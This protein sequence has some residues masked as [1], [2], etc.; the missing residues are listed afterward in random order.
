MNGIDI[1]FAIIF[2]YALYKGFRNGLIVELCGIISI[3]AGVFIAY[4]FSDMVAGWLSISGETGYVIAFIIIMIATLLLLG[5]LARIISKIIDFTGFG[6]LNKLMGAIAS[7][8]KIALLAG[9]LTC[10]F[11]VLN[12]QAHWIEQKTLDES[13]LYAPM[14]Q[15]AELVFPYLHLVNP[16][17]EQNIKE[18]LPFISPSQE[19]EGNRQQ[20]ETGLPEKD[21]GDNDTGNKTNGDNSIIEI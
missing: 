5:I 4:H 15:I 11:D 10:A 14:E 2:L 18:I 1:F 20:T 16:A 21:T 12:K 7:L 13:K 17:N 9:I 19:Q 8:L 6:T 3:I